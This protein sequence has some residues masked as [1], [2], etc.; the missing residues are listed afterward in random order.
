MI[1][2]LLT[3]IGEYSFGAEMA[4]GLTANVYYDTD[5]QK[6]YYQQRGNPNGIDLSHR[7]LV[8]VNFN[9]RTHPTTRFCDLSQYD[10]DGTAVSHLQDGTVVIRGIVKYDNYLL[11]GIRSSSAASMIPNDTQIWGLLICI[12]L[13]SFSIVW[14]HAYNERIS[15][16]ALYKSPNKINYL[17]VNGRMGFVRFYTIDNKKDLSTGYNA[18]KKRDIQYTTGYK[19]VRPNDYVTGMQENHHGSWCIIKEQRKNVNVMP[20]PSVKYEYSATNRVIYKYVYKAG[21]SPVF[22]EYVS[23]RLYQCRLIKGKYQWVRSVESDYTILFVSAGFADGVHVF[24]VTNLTDSTYADN[25]NHTSRIYNWDSRN[26]KDMWYIIPNPGADGY[27]GC[28]SFDAV[29]QYPYVYAT[30]A[31]SRQVS[32]YDME[33]KTNYRKMGILTLNISDL[34]NITATEQFIPT[35][36]MGL[37][38]ADTDSPPIIITKIYNRL[39]L[40]NADK[41]VAVFDISN[42]ANP[43]FIGNQTNSMLE[44]ATGIWAQ[45]DENGK[46]SFLIVGEHPKGQKFADAGDPYSPYARPKHMIFYT[47]K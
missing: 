43:Q 19:T 45:D 31:P 21:V 39:Y 46:G 42:P 7:G 16:L 40:G 28:H 23:G 25:N 5:N 10:A 3:P 13:A 1:N 24:D 17:I 26:H 37:M 35:E 18:L 34:T 41:G 20:E 29:V 47:V 32:V 4:N 22:S 12:D 8:E 6:F 38:Y 36:E 9:N 44:N 11:L 33:N 27:V 2:D 30:L 14:D 15:G